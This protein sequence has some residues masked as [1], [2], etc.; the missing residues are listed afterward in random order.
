MIPKTQPETDL[1][2]RQGLLVLVALGIAAASLALLYVLR[3]GV[4]TVLNMLSPFLVALILAYIF[5]P[6]VRLFQYRLK[7][8]RVMGVAVAY[9]L[10]LLIAGVFLAIV[11]PILYVQ[12]RD[13]IMALSESVPGAVEKI[14][15]RFKVNVT[16]EEIQQVRDAIRSQL[17]GRGAQTAGA[18]ANYAAT[19]VAVLSRLVVTG[20]GVVLG[21][22]AFLAFVVLISFYFL[23]DYAKIGMTLRMMMK[24]A[25]AERF[26][27]IW[28]RIDTALGGY[29]RGQL[30]IC[31]ILAVLYFVALNLLGMTSY[32]VLL[33]FAAGFGNLIPYFGPIIGGVPA[34]LWVIFGDTFTTVESKA[35]AVLGIAIFTACVQGLDGFFLQPRI[36]GKAADLHPV[37]VLL[38]LII[39]AQ[40]GLG[41]LIVAVPAAIVVRTLLLALWWE[42]LVEKRRVQ[43]AA[44]AE[45]GGGPTRNRTSN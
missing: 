45:A 31:V 37:T 42:P 15:D 38:A 18:L 7:V 29:L 4:T 43:E 22:F 35:L 16:D 19:G 6:V 3:G 2:L 8:S 41:G 11:V 30:F 33:G 25:T 10:I 1:R 40:F 13:G 14:V 34:V 39:G 26:F 27:E 24:P 44:V 21:S 36:V 32:S 17:D 5:N 9:G 12:L 23:L 20:I 28:A